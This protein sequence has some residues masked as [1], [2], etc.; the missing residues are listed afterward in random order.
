MST[1]QTDD[2]ARITQEQF[3]VVDERFDKV[4]ERLDRLEAGQQRLE[5]GIQKLEQ[6]MDT[7]LQR[8]LDVVLEIP[9]KKV[10]EKLTHKL[11]DHDDQIGI[12]ERKLRTISH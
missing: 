8:V 11:E 3:S 2:L 10:I 4:D 7:K 6:K 12:I 9:S 1:M 5:V